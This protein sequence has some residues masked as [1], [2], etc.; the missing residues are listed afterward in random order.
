[1]VAVEIA[2]A[3]AAPIIAGLALGL[4][5]WLAF[6]VRGMQ[7]VARSQA[8]TARSLAEVASRLDS[9][10]HRLTRLE[11]WQDGVAFARAQAAVEREGR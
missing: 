1:M 2:D 9:H 11:A 4:V 10:E 3:Y 8:D 5:S 6:M 7:Q